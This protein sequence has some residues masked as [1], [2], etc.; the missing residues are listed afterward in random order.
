MKNYRVKF[1]SSVSFAV[2]FRIPK[3][4][5]VIIILIGNNNYANYMNSKDY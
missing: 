4:Y 5:R 2:Y 3:I 1:L